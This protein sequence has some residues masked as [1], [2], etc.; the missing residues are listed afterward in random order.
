[1]QSLVNVC[2]L[3]LILLEMMLVAALIA[4]T[5]TERRSQGSQGSQGKA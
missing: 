2:A 3:D 4:V 1:M 5:I